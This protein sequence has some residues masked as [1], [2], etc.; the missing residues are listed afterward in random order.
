MSAAKEGMIDKWNTI[1]LRVC[2]EEEETRSLVLQSSVSSTLRL[3][4][5]G[6]RDCKYLWALGE[7]ERNT[8]K[9]ECYQILT[10]KSTTA[11]GIIGQALHLCE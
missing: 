10:V 9:T 6:K 3:E 5:S 4:Q 2:R 11:P 1:N 7:A 8:K